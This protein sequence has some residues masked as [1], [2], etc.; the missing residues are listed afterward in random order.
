MHIAIGAVMGYDLIDKFIIQFATSTRQPRRQ[1]HLLTNVTFCHIKSIIQR[2]AFA[3][4]SRNG[5]RKIVTLSMSVLR[6][7]LFLE[8]HPFATER[9]QFLLGPSNIIRIIDFLL[10]EIF[11]IPSLDDDQ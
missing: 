1:S 6:Q 7:Y 3:K 9:E 4:I 8:N 5:R 2:H 11:G 10:K